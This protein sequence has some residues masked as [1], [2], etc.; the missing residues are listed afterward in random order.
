M[1]KILNLFDE[2]IVAKI[3]KERVLPQYPD[4]SGIKKIEIHP[5][6]KYIW[7]STY[8]VVLEYK[9]AFIAKDKKIK[10]LPIICTAHSD[11][12]RKNVYIS[13]KFLWSRGFNKGNLTIPH[14]LF[15]SNFYRA[16]FYRG[17][18]GVN[19]YQFI[20]E[21]NFTEI[22]RIIPLAA[23]WFAKLHKLPIDGAKNFNKENSR[24][25][26]VIPGSKHVINRVREHAPQYLE[27][28]EKIYQILDNE[29]KKIFKS[30][31]KRWLIHGDAHPE[32]VIKVSDKKIALI[33]F[34]DICLADFARDLGAFIQQ[35]EFMGQR[36][37]GNDEYIAKLKKLFLD[38]Y[39]KDAKIKLD[40]ALRKRIDNYYHWTALRTA[41]FFLLKSQPEPERAHGLLV[42]IC[43]DM[44]LDC[45]V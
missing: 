5:Y 6:K 21:K 34:T 10:V 1:N 22:E 26:T 23:R 11:E 4:F 3:I 44:K 41:S 9:V 27:A 36:K 8:H 32:N 13:L 39:L 15:Y 24:I 40:N 29:E 45:Q 35:I 37:I 42:K 25:A 12:P 17:V 2:Q 20:R 18:K 28:Y 33:D 38:S 30:T 19:L 16:A 14:P 43:Q 31:K 7:E